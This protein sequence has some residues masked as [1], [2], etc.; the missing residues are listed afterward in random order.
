MM[1]KKIGKLRCEIL[2]KNGEKL[3]ITLQDVKYVP[4]LWVN[5]FSIG[6]ALKNGFNLGNDGERIKLMKGNVTIVFDRFLTSKNGFVPGIKM[7]QLLNDVS[8]TAVES[9]KEKLKNMIDVNN[10]HKILG[11]CGEASARLTG[12]ALGYEIIGTYDTCEACSIG[13]ARQKNVNKDWKG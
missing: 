7:K 1:A 9:K 13:K 3:I 6:K 8:T 11:H 12:K 4:E 2:Q 10:L 5:L